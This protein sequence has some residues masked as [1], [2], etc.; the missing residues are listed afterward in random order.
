MKQ[1]KLESALISYVNART[2]NPSK[3]NILA[4]ARILTKLKRFNEANNLNEIA[5]G[6]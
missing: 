4:N 3:M 5:A 2:L 1:N 6:L